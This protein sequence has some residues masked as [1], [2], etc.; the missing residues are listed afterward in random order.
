MNLH[1][2]VIV[3]T[4]TNTA[5]AFHSIWHV[6]L[7]MSEFPAISTIKH[8]HLHLIQQTLKDFKV[9][10]FRTILQAGLISNSN[11]KPEKRLTLLSVTFGCAKQHSFKGP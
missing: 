2:P 9:S 3:S 5:F 10:Y 7:V 11:S 1:L 8:P 4:K 6:V